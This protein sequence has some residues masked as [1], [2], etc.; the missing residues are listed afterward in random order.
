M[1]EHTLSVLEF[2]KIKKM[3]T[4]YTV[5]AIAEEIVDKVEPQTNFEKILA[6]QKETTE[7]R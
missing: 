3:L 7:M 5:S 6:I 2:S 1:D 4:K